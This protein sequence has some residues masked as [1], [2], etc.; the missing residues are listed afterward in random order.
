MWVKVQLSR[1]TGQRGLFSFISFP[2]FSFF[3]SSFHP[4]SLYLF[5]WDVYP[6]PGGWPFSL[7]VPLH[8]LPTKVVDHFTWKTNTLKSMGI[9]SPTSAWNSHIIKGFWEGTPHLHTHHLLSHMPIALKPPCSLWS[10]SIFEKV[11]NKKSPKR[12]YKW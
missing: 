5:G 1:K 2:F 9:C 12:S 10:W 6:F 11:K 4:F 8:H 3:L 7:H